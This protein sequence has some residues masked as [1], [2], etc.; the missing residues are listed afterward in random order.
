MRQ[1]FSE[2]SVSSCWGS[3]TT[4]ACMMHSHRLAVLIES[5]TWETKLNILL[6]NASTVKLDLIG[7]RL[8]AIFPDARIS[9]YKFLNEAFAETAQRQFDLIVNGYDLPVIESKQLAQALRATTKNY[10]TPTILFPKLE[11]HHHQKS[12]RISLGDSVYSVGDIVEMISVAKS[13]L[14]T[15]ER[16]VQVA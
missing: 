11:N 8:L 2:L 5:A 6:M 16:S 9:K 10:I 13:I 3:Q 12:L 7:D 15:E 14:I 4:V 1:S